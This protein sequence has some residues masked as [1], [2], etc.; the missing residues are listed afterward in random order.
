MA[1]KFLATGQKFV[2]F[3]AADPLRTVP[4]TAHGVNYRWKKG[5]KM[6][7]SA[8]VYEIRNVFKSIFVRCAASRRQGREAG[9]TILEVLKI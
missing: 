7:G 5:E 4:A 1:R 2:L 3:L 9:T 8:R 6:S